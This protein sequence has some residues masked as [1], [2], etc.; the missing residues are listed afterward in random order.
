MMPHVVPVQPVLVKPQVGHGC[1]ASGVAKVMGIRP[2]MPGLATAAAGCWSLALFPL[3][4]YVALLT[5]M[6]R[7]I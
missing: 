7:S 5:G 4:D 1:L 6:G 2:I 3:L